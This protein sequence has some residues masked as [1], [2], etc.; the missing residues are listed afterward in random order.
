MMQDGK[1]LQ[2]GTSHFLGQNFAKSFDVKFVNKENQLEYAWA[3]SWG[4]STRLMGALIMA[5][6]DDN[7][8]VLPPK[9]A[10]IQVVIVPIYKTPEDLAAI[11]EKVDP[12]LRRAESRGDFGQVRRQ[13]Q[14]AFGMEVCRVRAARECRSGSGSECAIS[15]TERSRSPAATR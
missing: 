10:P 9:L 2:A 13:R 11:S 7:G 4:V 3:T 14:S 6:S 12:D 8:L 15:R 1:A 5:H